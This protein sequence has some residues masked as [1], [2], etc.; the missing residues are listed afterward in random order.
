MDVPGGQGVEFRMPLGDALKKEGQDLDL[1]IV[2]RYRLFPVDPSAKD[3]AT[4]DA[5]AYALDFETTVENRSG[6]AVDL[7]L[8]HEALAGV[9]LEGW[10]YSVK[11]SKYFFKGAG[12]RDVR[13]RDEQGID[14][15]VMARDIHT[16]ELKTPL[17]Q[18]LFINV[19]QP[20][21]LVR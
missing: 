17:D 10:W 21:R 18:G 7:S 15:I 11:V 20:R 6:K 8:R 14:S 16:R 5:D 12:L 19:G 4:A 13:F 1:V 3:K 2:K 9:T